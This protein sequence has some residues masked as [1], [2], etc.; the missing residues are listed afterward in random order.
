MPTPRLTVLLSDPAFSQAIV[1]ALEEAKERTGV[2]F[3]VV[4][5]ALYGSVVKG[6]ETCGDIDVFVQIELTKQDVREYAY[7]AGLRMDEDSGDDFFESRMF[8]ANIV[9]NTLHGSDPAFKQPEYQGVSLDICI[10]FDAFHE[11]IGKED[12]VSLSLSV[13]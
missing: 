6:S 13:A 12:K 5:S 2:D 10:S 4:E 8:V 7:D 3:E 11:E 9:H 1:A